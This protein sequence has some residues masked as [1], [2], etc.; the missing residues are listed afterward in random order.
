[1]PSIV[2]LTAPEISETVNSGVLP[3][4]TVALAARF[5]VDQ[6]VHERT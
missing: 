6:I 4:G 2:R 5:V 1:L 3:G